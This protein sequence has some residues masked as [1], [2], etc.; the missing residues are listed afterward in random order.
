MCVCVCVSVCVCLCVFVCVC[1]CV[2]V[3]VSVCVCVCVCM[4]VCVCV[5]VCMCVCSGGCVFVFVFVFVFVCVC[6]CVCVCVIVF[7]SGEVGKTGLRRW[8]VGAIAGGG[9]LRDPRG[10]GVSSPTGVEWMHSKRVA[11]DAVHA[12]RGGRM[13]RCMG[14]PFRCRCDVLDARF[15]LMPSWRRQVVG[16]QLFALVLI[17]K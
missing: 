7:V 4:C 12:S 17:N 14:R 6:V 3:C 5:C 10:R 16:R 11:G 9:G 8:E 2:Y 15:C 13:L 1:V